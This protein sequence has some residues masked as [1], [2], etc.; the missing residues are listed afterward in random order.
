MTVRRLL[1]IAAFVALTVMTTGCLSGAS[2]PPTPQTFGPSKGTIQGRV[3]TTACGG[4]VVKDT[5]PPTNYRGSLLFCRTMNQI[6][7]CPSAQVD[8]TGHYQIVLK[9]GRYALIPAPSSG[10][11]VGVKPR[12]VSVDIGQTTTLNIDGGTTLA[13]AAAS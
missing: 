7:F 9:A 12:W 6:G 4:P 1:L 8:A 10:N 2:T 3:L 13:K 11:V 5:C